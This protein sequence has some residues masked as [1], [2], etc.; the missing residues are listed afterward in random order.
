[1]NRAILQMTEFDIEDVCP[2]LHQRLN[3]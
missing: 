3:Y 2:S 1:M